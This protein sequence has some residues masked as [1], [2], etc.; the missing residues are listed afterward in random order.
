M[1]ATAGLNPEDFKSVTEAKL[2]LSTNIDVSF[3]GEAGEA[4]DLSELLDLILKK[5]PSGSPLANNELVINIVGALGDKDN[6]YLNAKL[7]A[8][9]DLATFSLEVALVVNRYQT[10]GEKAGEL[11]NTLLA[12]YLKDDSVYIDLSGILG[13]GVMVSITNLGLNQLLADKLGGL[14]ASAGIGGSSATEAVTATIEDALGMTL[15]DYAYLG[16]LIN[17]GYFSLQL[18]A[19][20]IN[21]IVAKIG[22]ENPDLKLDFVLPDFGDIM[23]AAHGDKADGAKLSINA[24]FAEGFMGAIDI[25]TL[26]LGTEPVFGTEAGRINLDTSKFSEVYNATTGNIAENFYLSANAFVEVSMTSEGLKPGDANYDNSLAGWG[27][28]TITNLLLGALDETMLGLFSQGLQSYYTKLSTADAQAWKDKGGILYTTE[29]PDD[30]GSY[31]EYKG[32]ISDA[33]ALYKFDPKVNVTFAENDVNL[34]I[35]IAA[36]IDLGSIVA[37]G[38]GG[39]LFSDLKLEIRLGEPFNSQFLTVYYLGSSRLEKKATS[40]HSVP[41]A[42]CSPMQFTSMQAASVLARLSSKV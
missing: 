33:V 14:L 40:T 42:P 24:K 41:T 4:V 12:V 34:I 36:D 6:P 30:L 10:E 39:I 5:I 17:P 21:A 19:M 8:Y 31:T 15:H 16:V 11:G 3:F 28:R 1:Q 35:D 29:T 27:I 13:D 18:T 7:D 2:R 37:F 38:I 25:N 20:V 22:E 32:E 9:I 23:I 26:T